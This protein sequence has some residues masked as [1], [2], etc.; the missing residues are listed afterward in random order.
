MKT[1][2]L[3]V[4]FII[5]TQALAAETCYQ[6]SIDG[7]TWSEPTETLCISKLPAGSSS[8]YRID[9]N[10]GVDQ[11][12]KTIASY[13]LNSLPSGADTLAFGPSAESS[14]IFDE[15][16]TIGVGD[17]EAYVGSQK[18]FAKKL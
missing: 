9:L 1:L 2:F 6:L 12:K 18:F 16:V 14:T 11:K 5:G 8:E 4:S 13:F 17:G 3:C 10:R 15:S 7:V